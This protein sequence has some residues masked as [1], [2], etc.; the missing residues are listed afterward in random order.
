MWLCIRVFGVKYHAELAAIERKW[1]YLKQQIR[2]LLDGSIPT[3]RN[4]LVQYWFKYT[5]LQ[6]HND[7]RH[8]RETGAVYKMMGDNPSLAALGVGQ[9]EYKGHRRVFDSVTMMFRAQ[10]G[11]N[12][13]TLANLLE[14]ART[15]TA[16]MNKI[17]GDKWMKE[18][19]ADLISFRRRKAAKEKKENTIRNIT[20]VFLAIKLH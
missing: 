4:L 14:A 16:R 12:K 3:L 9:H 6:T 18:S 1:M 2:G 5:V 17:E 15:K 20:A 7:S 8:V 13:M 11:A 19:K 10:Y